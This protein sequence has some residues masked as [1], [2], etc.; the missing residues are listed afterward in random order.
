VS[1]VVLVM[2]LVVVG[3]I[4]FFKQREKKTAYNK[5]TEHYSQSPQPQENID[6]HH[7]Y[8]RQ[9]PP[10]TPHIATDNKK[11]YSVSL[12]RLSL[13]PSRRSSINNIL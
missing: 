5:W 6:I 9:A 10:F 13:S 2:V 7:F 11:R 4:C 1:V 12:Q 8:S 3:I